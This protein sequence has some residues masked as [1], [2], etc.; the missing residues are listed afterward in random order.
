MISRELELVLH[1]A[2]VA[3]RQGRHRFVTVEHI[4]LEM[5]EQETVAE[6]LTG[7]SVDL[8]ALRSGLAAAL[9]AMEVEPGRGDPDPQPTPAFQRALQTAILNVQRDNRREVTVLD[10]LAAALEHKEGSFAGRVFEAAGG[11]AK[12]E[13]LSKITAFSCRLCD[14]PTALESL[15]EIPGRGFMC[16]PCIAAVKAFRKG[17]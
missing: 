3:A 1:R 12:P 11:V 9:S 7:C 13:D 14:K 10:V 4:G 16:Q 5:L 2:F 15:S 17:P 8:E 6:H